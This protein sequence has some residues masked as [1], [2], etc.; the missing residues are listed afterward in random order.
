MYTVIDWRA[1]KALGIKESWLTVDD[2][3]H[4]YEKKAAELG[5]GLRDLDRALWMLGGE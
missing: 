1:L 4:F 3:L 5:I 2:Y